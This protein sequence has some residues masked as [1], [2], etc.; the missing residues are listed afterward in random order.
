[1]P[2]DENVQVVYSTGDECLVCEARIDSGEV[3]LDVVFNVDLFVTKKQIRKQ[4][5]VRCGEA[6]RTLLDTRIAQ[7]K[8]V[9]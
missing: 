1:M 6:L 5:H 8:R 4:M 9:R 3:A 7:A 2:V